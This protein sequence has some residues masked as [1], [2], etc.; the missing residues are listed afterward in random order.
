MT[1]TELSNMAES[2]M[3]LPSKIEAVQHEILERTIESSEISEQIVRMESKI[4]SDINAAV[5]ANG[6]K[7][8]SNDVARE[9]AFIDEVENHADLMSRQNEVQILQ[10]EIQ[11]R[12]IEIECLNNKQR[13]I[14]SILNFFANSS[15]TADQF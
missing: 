14:R 13:N 8:Y 3:E 7:I 12:K 2:L 4:K 10:K 6:K 11:E 15:E 9:A 5:D 1:H